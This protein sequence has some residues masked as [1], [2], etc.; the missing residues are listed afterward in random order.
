MDD[1]LKNYER[2]IINICW[3][4]IVLLAIDI[5]FRLEFNI[6]K[7]SF[8]NSSATVAAGLTLLL[9]AFNITKTLIL[10]SNNLFSE[11]AHNIFRYA[12]VLICS[13]FIV[14][15][16]NDMLVYLILL[17][18]VLFSS[19]HSTRYKGYILLGINLLCI[20]AYLTFVSIFSGTPVF[21]KPDF[22]QNLCLN[23]GIDIIIIVLI[24]ISAAISRDNKKNEAENARLIV[25]IGEKY[26]QLAAAQ[27]Q[28]K[29]QYDKLKESNHRMEDTNRKLT[30]SIAEFYT[31]QQISEAINSIFDINELLKF[32]NDV[33]IGV[34]GVNYS[35][36][37]LLDP[38]KNR[39]KV[40]FTNIVNREELAI[41]NDNINCNLLSGV[42]LNE[43][44]ILENKADSN[45]YDFIRTREVGSFICIPLSSKSRKFGIVLIEHK[46]NDTFDM[47]NLRLLTTIGKQVSMA[48]ENAQ[49]YQNLQEM[50]TIDGLTQVFNRVYFHEK[51]LKEY[52]QSQESGYCLS[53][54][55]C[56]IDFFKKFNDTYGHLFGDVVLKT[57]AQT[58]KN[59]LR[60]SDTVARF[61]GEEFVMILPRTTIQ[62]AY[63]RVEFLRHKI[64]NTVVKDNLISVSVTV[65]FGIACFPET[66]VNQNELIKDADN[67][68]YKAKESGR[69]CVK[70]AKEIEIIQPTTRNRK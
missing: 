62:E 16:K 70:L 55:I 11:K 32:V 61:G 12:E 36:I 6:D 1:K 69:N 64:E 43:K 65:S 53:L 33:I 27:E 34:M 49:L 40:Q 28:I 30:C 45:K 13:A 20:V 21:Q 4:I 56:D 46:N 31:L 44:P 39:L 19:Y 68:L 10:K 8:K 52:Y 9:I 26:E 23:I 37:I 66:S 24:E 54:V 41:L 3:G 50:A 42:L 60:N 48:I 2:F 18:S 7:V 59:S 67:A 25:E 57:V 63:E 5:L 47:E 38:A 35:T 17:L 51:F 22:A 29:N 58:I 15:L 14:V